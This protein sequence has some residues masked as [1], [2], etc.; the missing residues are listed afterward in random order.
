MERRRG[1]KT[2]ASHAQIKLLLVLCFFLFGWPSGTGCSR[3]LDYEQ[4]PQPILPDQPDLAA[5]YWEVWAQINRQIQPREPGGGIERPYIFCGEDGFIKQW[6]TCFTALFAM[7][8]A[9][10]FPVMSALDN[11]YHNQRSDGF[12]PREILT[13]AES[14][15]SIPTTRDPMI[16]PPLFNWVERKYYSMTGDTSR[17]RR[18]YPVLERYFFWLEA[19][20]HGKGQARD[21]FYS[22]PFCSNMLNLPRGNTEYGGWTDMSAQMAKFAQDLAFFA[23]VLGRRERARFFNTY[24]QNLAAVIQSKLWA[25]DSGFYYD[26]TRDG[27]LYQVKTLAGFW[28]LWAGIPTVEPAG[29]LVNHLRDTTEFYRP[30]LFPTVAA[31]EKEY[32][33]AG[34]YWRGS[35]CGALN[36]MVL[37]GLQDYGYQDFATQAAWNHL[38]NMAQ[39]FQGPGPANASQVADFAAETIWQFY[40]P[41][42]IAPATRWDSE[43]YVQPDGIA[44]SGQGPVAMLIENILGFK[45]FGPKQHVRWRI[46]LYDK[47]GIKNLRFGSY[48]VSLWCEKRREGE[49]PLVI[50]GHTN[51]PLTIS[52]ETDT[53]QFQAHFDSG[54]IE[55]VIMPP[56]YIM[57]DRPLPDL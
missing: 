7:Y 33:P 45:V 19:R 20:C 48:Q 46:R 12:I 44:Y 32:N 17:L 43:D 10:Y 15:V 22:T 52:F 2:N 55:L 34:F 54:P 24:Y 9:H 21:L 37:A 38:N 13:V 53:D 14:P 1:F 47:H 31:D 25:P 40:S 35:V 6:S 39:I 18:I 3:A 41:E 49:F 11:F 50:H 57:A 29:Q 51:L 27:K 56:K 5:M 36:Y 16:H 23:K 26:Q 30:H 42:K 8:G 28:P 4:L